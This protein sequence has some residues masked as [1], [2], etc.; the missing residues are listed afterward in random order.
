MAVTTRRVALPGGVDLFLRE[1]GEGEPATLL[2]HGWAVPGTVWD[3][4]LEHWPAAG[5][6]V[7]APDLR[8]TGWSSKPREGYALAD[9]VA[10]VLALI[11]AIDA[12]GGLNLV[13]HSKGGL[14]AQRVA[15]ERPQALRK[16]VLVSPVP[17]AGV[18]LDEATV[19]FFESLCGHREGAEQLI[20]MMLA[21]PAAP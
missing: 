5:G 15:I 14:I 4:V 11:D 21:S 9:D 19:G 18:A 2:I 13:G 8:G 10:D 16:L 17:A 3:P 20:G 7:L 6:R 1:L 12:P